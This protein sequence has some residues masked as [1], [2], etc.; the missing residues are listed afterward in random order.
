V[1]RRPQPPAWRDTT[2]LPA[3]AGHAAFEAC[4][5][6]PARDDGPDP[7]DLAVDRALEVAHYG[8]P[9]GWD[10]ADL[11]DLA[12]EGAWNRWRS[13]PAAIAYANRVTGRTA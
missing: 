4:P 5:T 1:K 8:P 12:V 2:A 13:L 6:V 11:F 9:S 3:G 7:D 10:D